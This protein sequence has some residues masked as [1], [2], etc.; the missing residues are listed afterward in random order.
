MIPRG[1]LIFLGN[2]NDH[3]YVLIFRRVKRFK[4][5]FASLRGSQRP[6][7]TTDHTLDEWDVDVSH[8]QH[9]RAYNPPL[10]NLRYVWL[11]VN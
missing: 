11:L 10:W 6:L 4:V 1:F 7:M 9:V 2:R 3:C 8:V 5:S